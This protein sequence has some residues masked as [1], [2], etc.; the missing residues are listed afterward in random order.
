MFCFRTISEKLLRIY[1][2][3]DPTV[4]YAFCFKIVTINLSY[5]TYLGT[6]ERNFEKKIQENII[7]IR[8]VV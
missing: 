5:S 3:N 8:I 7:I 2:N 1:S 4:L 6:I